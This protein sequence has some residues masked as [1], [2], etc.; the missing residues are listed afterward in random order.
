ME[1]KPVCAK[2]RAIEI[3]AVSVRDSKDT[4]HREESQTTRQ[5]NRQNDEK[6]QKMKRNC[7]VIGKKR[8]VTPM[9]E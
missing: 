5:I 7:R 2:E 6:T 4:S 8:T 9:T 1:I 3:H